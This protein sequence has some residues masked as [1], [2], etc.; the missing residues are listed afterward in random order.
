MYSLVE[1]LVSIVY[2]EKVINGKWKAASGEGN[3]Q[4]LGYMMG[5]NMKRLHTWTKIKYK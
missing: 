2:R 3:A 1:R 5:S 4:G